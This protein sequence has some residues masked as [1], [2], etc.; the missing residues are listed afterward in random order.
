[1]TQRLLIAIHVIRV[2]DQN[3]L[4]PQL[5]ISILLGILYPEVSIG[6]LAGGTDR[7]HNNERPS[8]GSNLISC[9][10]YYWGAKNIPVT[11]SPLT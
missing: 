1:V 3:T 5:R 4:P 6:C 7:W 2:S 9:P 10:L 8:F 11:H